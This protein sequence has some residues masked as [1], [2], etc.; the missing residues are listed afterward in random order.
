MKS[1]EEVVCTFASVFCRPGSDLLFRV[2]RRST[3]GAEAFNDRVR[4]GIG[5]RHLAIATRPAKDRQSTRVFLALLLLRIILSEKSATFRDD[6]MGIENEN[7]QAIR[8]ISTSKLHALRR[9]HTWPINVV[10]FHG[11]QGRNGFEVDFP[12]RCLQR[13]FRPHIATL[14]YR[15][16]DNRSTEIGRAHV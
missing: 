12:L 11:S 14:L 6:A 13:L 2:L 15:W 8:T 3:I 7:D 5:F 9:F 4:D 16:R 1:C 10:V